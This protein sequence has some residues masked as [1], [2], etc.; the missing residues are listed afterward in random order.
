MVQAVPGEHNY[1]SLFIDAEDFLFAQ[2]SVSK[3][4]NAAKQ[5]P[6]RSFV[7]SSESLSIQKGMRHLLYSAILLVV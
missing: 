1:D 5:D 4:R 6:Q 2:T 7:V 3:I